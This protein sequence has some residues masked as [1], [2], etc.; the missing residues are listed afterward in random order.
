[1]ELRI[2]KQV[3]FIFAIAILVVFAA[4]ESNAST[5]S[6]SN[7]IAQV[8]EDDST[9][10]PQGMDESSVEEDEE[11]SMPAEPAPKE[12]SDEGMLEE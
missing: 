1:M 8:S 6:V 10:I 4:I 7:Q 9:S 2:K 5:P 12:I 11:A 3:I